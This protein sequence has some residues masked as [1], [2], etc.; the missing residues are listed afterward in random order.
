MTNGRSQSD[1]AGSIRP[2]NLDSV[3]VESDREIQEHRTIFLFLFSSF[4]FLKSTAVV[5][6]RILQTTELI[7]SCPNP[8][9]QRSSFI[10]MAS[11]SFSFQSGIP[12]TRGLLH[13]KEFFRFYRKNFL[14]CNA[15]GEYL[16]ENLPI[17]AKDSLAN[18]KAELKSSSTN[19]VSSR[20]SS[21]ST[22]TFQKTLNRGSKKILIPRLINN[23]KIMSNAEL[24]P[25]SD[26]RKTLGVDYGDRRTGI[27]VTYKGFSPRILKV[28]ALALLLFFDAILN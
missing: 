25:G 1:F 14:V 13:R 6:Q 15:S 22:K 2:G 5:F 19:E 12:S 26:S 28:Q 24:P 21:D 16:D 3:K 8:S 18:N 17:R 11:C 27:A 9:V 23:K 20:N 4:F 10:L 7:L